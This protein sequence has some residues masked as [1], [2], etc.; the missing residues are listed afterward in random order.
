MGTHPIFESDFDCLTECVFPFQESFDSR[1]GSQVLLPAA[2]QSSLEQNC[3]I[4]A[5]ELSSALLLV[6]THMSFITLQFQKAKWNVPTECQI[7]QNT[8]LRI[9]LLIGAKSFIKLTGVLVSEV[10]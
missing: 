5:V 7:W 8:S 3:E 6:S 4:G 9:L 1:F 10:R 2:R